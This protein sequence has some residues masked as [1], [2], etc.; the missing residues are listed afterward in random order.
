ME[1]NRVFFEAIVARKCVEAV[2]NSVAVK[3]APHILYTRHDDI[4]VDAFTLERDGKPPKEKKLG[5][6]KLAGLKDVA[7]GGVAFQ[8][9]PVFNPNSEKYQG[10]TL[11]AI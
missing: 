1:T 3:L 6:F 7:V 10:V 5:T 2:Y 4:F 8:P 11:L 9:E